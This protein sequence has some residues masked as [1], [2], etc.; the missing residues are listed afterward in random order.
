MVGEGVLSVDDGRWSEPLTTLLRSAQSRVSSGA[1][2]DVACED[3]LTSLYSVATAPALGGKDPLRGP[4]LGSRDRARANP[5]LE[6]GATEL[7]G[8]ALDQ[9]GRWRGVLVGGTL[10]ATRRPA[11]EQSEGA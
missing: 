6:R 8:F 10:L 1:P 9:E 5:D 7:S 11:T 3:T 4:A 2:L